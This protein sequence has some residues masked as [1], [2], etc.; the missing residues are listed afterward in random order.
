M[1]Q[2]AAGVGIQAGSAF[3]GISD[4]V[5]IGRVLYDYD[6]PIVPADNL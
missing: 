4:T 3:T 2:N 1:G 5:A 6:F